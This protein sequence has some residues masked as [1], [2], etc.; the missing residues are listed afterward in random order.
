MRLWLMLA[1]CGAVL[2]TVSLAATSID[3]RPNNPYGVMLGMGGGDHSDF[4]ALHLD[5][6]AEMVG[7]WGHVRVGSGVHNVDLEYA[8]RTLVMCRAKKLTPIMT[9]LYVPE[10]YQ[11]PQPGLDA[12]PTL[13]DDGYPKAAE[14]YRRW[15]AGLAVLGAWPPYYEVGNEINGKWEPA[16]YGRF[17]IAISQALKSELPQMKVVSA[18]LAGHGGDFLEPMLREVPEAAD[19]IDCYGLHPYGANHPPAYE[20][21]GYCLKGHLWTARHL[22]AVGVTNPRFVMTES[23]YELGNKKDPYYPRITDPLRARYLVEAYETIWVPD[24]R[25]IAL[26]LFMLQATHYP[27]WH[28]W[29]FVNDDNTANESYKALAAVRKP[30]G[31]DWMP[32]GDAR[33]SGRM[34]DAES[35]Q[36]LP[37]VF[38]YTVP[39]LYAAETDSEG[40]YVIDRIPAGEYE[41][42]AFRDG[43]VSPPA[44][45]IQVG[46]TGSQTVEQLKQTGKIAGSAKGY[47]RTRYNA[48]RGRANQLEQEQA[49]ENQQ[50]YH[51][52]LSRVGLM[53]G[54]LDRGSTAAEGWSPFDPP[55]AMGDH[56]AV[57]RQ[58]RRN[59]DA[60]QRLT[61]RPGGTVGLWRCAA[62]ASAVPDRAYAAEVWVKGQGLRRGSG[63]GPTF[64]LS[65]TDSGAQPYESV[66]VSLPPTLEGDFDWTPL[67]ITVPPLPIARRIVLR[68]ALEAESG[69]VWFDD[70]YLHYADYPSPS[71]KGMTARGTAT[72]RG[73]LLAVTQERLPGGVVWLRPGNLAAFSQ[74]DGRFVLANIPAGT[75]DAW[76]C[77]YGWESISRFQLVVTDN[78]TLTMDFSLPKLPRPTGVQNPGFEEYGLEMGYTPGWM[79]FGEFDGLPVNGWHPELPEHPQGVQARTGERFAGSIA[80]SNVKNGGIYQ[81][82]AVEPGR[83]YEAG[84]WYYTYQTEDGQ[85]G[86]AVSR[87]GLDPTGGTDPNG[88][89]VIWS[90]YRPS[91]KTWSHMALKATANTDRMTLFL[92]HRQVVGLGFLLNIFDDVSFGLAT[93]PLPPALT[94]P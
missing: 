93:E 68:C 49:V 67:S 7:T 32:Q 19:H 77:A 51:A 66:T 82:L 9:G 10:E 92:E 80:G 84:V 45:R 79:R 94:K 74:S 44:A 88:P 8:K 25:V 41:V 50:V 35:G 1:V 20:K 18:G 39:G 69:T 17:I 12:A 52:Q 57:D 71:R 55:Q 72:L 58:V 37:R 28:G 63:K 83:T 33:I 38:V 73:E 46:W 47:Q 16:V 6:A 26:T 13:R 62:Y 42:F 5:Q 85:R 65:M 36:G 76:A 89:Y 90:P 23:G 53:D 4:F 21:D 64:A 61:A 29:I 22:A 81:V 3:G 2:S 78:Q 34:T 91:H 54:G 40:R 31:S 75:Y 24:P 43:F 56:Y 15:A 30:A 59:G 70:V 87:L 14:Q 86:D 27:G 11:I 48:R 60:S